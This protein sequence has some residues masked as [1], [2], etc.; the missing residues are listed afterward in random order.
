MVVRESAQRIED[1]ITSGVQF[2][3]DEGG[4]D[5]A[6]EG[7]HSSRRILHAKDATGAEI[8]RALIVEAKASNN[9]E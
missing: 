4:F 6:M 2:D 3:T 5:L 7:G 9:L 8:E 1:L